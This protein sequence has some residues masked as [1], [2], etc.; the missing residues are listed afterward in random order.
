MY[1]EI[2]HRVIYHLPGNNCFNQNLLGKYIVVAL[3][4]LYCKLVVFDGIYVSLNKLVSI[5]ILFS[6]VA[7]IIQFTL[8]TFSY[9]LKW[10][11]NYYLFFL[12][13]NGDK[14]KLYKLLGGISTYAGCLKVFKTPLRLYFMDRFILLRVC[15][16]VTSFFSWQ[17]M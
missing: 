4:F 1:K 2:N 8:V 6:T 5:L 15:L 14:S 12:D 11:S 10:T 3:H 17:K 9:Y 13:N 7:I 16:T